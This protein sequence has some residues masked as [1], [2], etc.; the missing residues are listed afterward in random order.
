MDIIIIDKLNKLERKILSRDLAQLSEKTQ[1]WGGADVIISRKLSKNN[2]KWLG[3]ENIIIS[4]QETNPKK[5]LV[6]TKYSKE[7]SWLFYQLR[8]LFSSKI[9][10]ISKYDFYG[11]LAQTAIDYI[12]NNKNKINTKELL[13]CVLDSSR[14]FYRA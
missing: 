4:M 7:L 8:D 11:I 12:N 6:V 13:L 5:R 14:S 10:Y 2:L 9:D 1:E 3:D